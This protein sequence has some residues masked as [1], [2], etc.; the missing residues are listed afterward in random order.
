MS[1]NQIVAMYTIVTGV[2]CLLSLLSLPL[3]I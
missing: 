2:L 3:N 1:E